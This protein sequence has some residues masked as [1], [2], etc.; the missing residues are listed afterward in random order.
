[1]GIQYL[2]D[3]KEENFLLKNKIIELEKL[4]QEQL[5]IS[6]KNKRLADI[7]FLTKVSNRMSFVRAVEDMLEAYKK[8]DYP[9]TLIYIDLDNF[10][11]VNDKYSHND[12]DLVLIEVANQL[13]V[14]NRAHTVIGRLGGEE[15]GILV[16]G[17]TDIEAA[18]IGERFRAL[19]E[20]MIFHHEDIH[21]T[22]SI[23][24]YSPDKDDYVDDIIYKADKAMY[25]SKNNGKNQFNLYR[26]LKDKI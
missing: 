14:A 12:G 6:R 24:I 4:L 1:M 22:A 20:N 21:I 7:D 16:P 10:K 17:L 25:F 19:I 18:T 3:L 2:K 9:F 26:D 8:K 23:G 13:V 11:Y 15:F 5:F